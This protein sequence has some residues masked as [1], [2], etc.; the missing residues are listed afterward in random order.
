MKITLIGKPQ[1]VMQNPDSHHNYFA[2]PTAARLQN[3][4][5]AVVASGFRLEHLCPFGKLVIAYSDDEGE[6]YSAPAPIMDTP[7]DDRD[8]GILPFGEK[9]V[10]VTSFN[11][12]RASYRAWAPRYAKT[13]E[14]L[15]YVNRYLDTVTDEQEERYL[16]AT[17]RMSRDGGITFGPIKKSPI[18]S[19][20]GPTLLSDG[21]ILWV[22]TVIR[23]E[24]E[25]FIAV[26]RVSPEGETEKLGTIEDIFYDGERQHSCEPYAIEL[27]DGSIL[28][29]IRV[30]NIGKSSVAG[31]L[32]TVF[33]SVSQDG[34]R[35]W[36]RPVQILPAKSGAPSH[37]LRH[38]SGV[39]VSTYGRRIT[40]YGIKAMFSLDNGKSWD[41]DHDLFVNDA[42]T[43]LGYPSTVE[44]RDG[45]LLTVF[46]ARPTPDAPS[47]VIMQQRWRF[48]K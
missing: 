19:P 38:S 3:G 42:T 8:G 7:L 1:I 4:R 29:H 20:H 2:W 31:S 22:G 18:T 21:T 6:S 25:N 44:L 11:H 34:G 30:Q 40:P 33:Q 43:D 35:T 26:Y 32:F 46:Y 16:G 17:F 24:K 36:S 10:M 15:E 14:M 5:I 12:P 23:G 27:P 9:G 39:L 13:P 48:E 37:I 45:S 28:C 41:V 47:V